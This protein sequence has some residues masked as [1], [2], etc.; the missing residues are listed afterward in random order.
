[1]RFESD[2]NAVIILSLIFDWNAAVY[3]TAF[4]KAAGPAAIDDASSAGRPA[5]S[6]GQRLIVG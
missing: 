6:V 5:S 4:R 1:M 2:D 3:E